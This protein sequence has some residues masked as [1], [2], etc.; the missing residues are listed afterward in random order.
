MLREQAGMTAAEAARRVD[1]DPTWLSRIEQLEGGIHP[2]DCK[3]LLDL[4]GVTGDVV[5]AVVTVARQA[6][7]RGWWQPYRDVMPEWFMTFVGL[8]SEASAI[9]TFEPQTVP[10]LLQTEDYARA[11]FASA[12]STRRPDEVDWKVALRMERQA[13]LAGDEPP[14]LRVVL[15]ESVLR[16][17][18]GGTAVTLAQIERLLQASEEAHTQIQVLPFAAGAHAGLYGAFV[19][20]DFPPFPE[21][22]PTTAADDRIV[23]VDTLLG[24]LYHEVD[25]EVAAYFAVFEHVRA[26]AL[27]TELSRE[28]LHKI[29]KDLTT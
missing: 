29:S 24:A 16:R 17:R 18:I 7:Q 21:P 6:K 14:Q 13:L 28:L 20:L 25:A 19:I 12:A 9:R 4:Y 23:Y 5:E 22:Y 2:N 1:H 11:T 27:S 15:D 10:G 8:E 3:A 26:E